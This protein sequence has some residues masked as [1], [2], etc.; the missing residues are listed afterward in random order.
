MFLSL[1]IIV[2]TFHHCRK[3]KKEEIRKHLAG[4]V[5]LS[6][7]NSVIYV[8]FPNFSIFLASMHWISVIK[9]NARLTGAR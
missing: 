7:L 5:M 6:S 2:S 3:K 9:A 8:N 4:T 1:A